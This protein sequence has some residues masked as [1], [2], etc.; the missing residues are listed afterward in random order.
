MKKQL[1]DLTLHMDQLRSEISPGADV[2]K[3][4]WRQTQLIVW[5]QLEI[6]LP[7]SQAHLAL[8][9]SRM[10]RRTLCKLMFLLMKA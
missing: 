7:P 8:V 4:G 2:I 9:G 10:G 5:I 1:H 6:P 3:G